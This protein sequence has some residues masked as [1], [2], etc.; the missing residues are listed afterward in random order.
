M[1]ER[2]VRKTRLCK[3]GRPAVAIKDYWVT[4]SKAKKSSLEADAVN[5]KAECICGIVRRRFCPE[6]LSKLASRQIM[7]NRKL[8]TIILVSILIPLIMA[9]GKFAFDF[10]ALNDGSALVPLIVTAVFTMLSEGIIAFK[11]RVAQRK[12]IR[13]KNGDISNA[14]FVSYMLDFLNFGL[15]EAEKI[16]EISSLD[17]VSDGDGRVNYNMERSGFNMRIM[18]N[19][20]I[21]IEPM[22]ER[23]KYPFSEDTEYVYRAYSNAGLQKDNI[24]YV[25]E[26]KDEIKHAK[27]SESEK[28]NDE[29]SKKLPEM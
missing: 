19:G 24:G 6:C 26:K 4:E 12:R 23:M 14:S 15:D 18:L 5:E 3:C 17:I 21:N 8:N 9:V 11:L 10:F 22:T 1:N 28:D 13:V 7:E 2:E 16:K 29:N 27:N 25:D 20:K